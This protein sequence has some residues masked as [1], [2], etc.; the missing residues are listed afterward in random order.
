MVVD[1]RLV[2]DAPIVV[3]DA[4]PPVDAAPCIRNPDAAGTFVCGRGDC[5]LGRVCVN[6][7]EGPPDSYCDLP[8]D[9]GPCSDQGV[10]FTCRGQCKIDRH[11]CWP[12]A[13]KCYGSCADVLA[14]GILRDSDCRGFAGPPTCV[15]LTG[16]GFILSCGPDAVPTCP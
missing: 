3:I 16:G 9:A 12:Y 14:E 15:E 7:I 2:F 13:P 11:I 1:A 5:A 10:C 4:P 8:T 6:W